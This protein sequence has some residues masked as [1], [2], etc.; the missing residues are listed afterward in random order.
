MVP[1]VGTAAGLRRLASRP[2]W[3]AYFR[4]RETPGLDWQP[5][6]DAVSASP[7]KFDSVCIAGVSSS[8]PG[9]KFLID[10]SKKVNRSTGLSRAISSMRRAADWK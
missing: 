4:F 3:R 2:D 6:L 8:S 9:D 10:S 1:P 7:P 5:S